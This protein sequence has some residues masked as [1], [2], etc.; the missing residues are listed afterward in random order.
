V[1]EFAGKPVRV[2]VIWEPVLATDWSSPS[3][4]TLKRVSD[5][6]AVQ[7]WDKGRLISHSMGEH[8]RR[9]V[10][11]DYIAVYPRGAV[12]ED[13]PRAALYHGG[14]VVQVVEP[15]RAALKKALRESAQSR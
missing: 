4:A 8:D 9:S 14:P 15:A 7:F 12:W 10:V 1:E 5:A 11:W 3:T 6:R 13:G 2:F